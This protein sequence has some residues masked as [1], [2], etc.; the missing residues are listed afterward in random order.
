MAFRS[1]P[2]Q[3]GTVAVSI[4][5]LTAVLILILVGSGFRAANT[6]DP[7]TKAAI[8]QVH[9][10]IAVGVLILTLLRVV[11]WW[12]FDRKPEPVGGSPN[13]QE[14]IANAVHVLFYVVVLGMIASGVG[15]MALSGAAPVIFSGEGVLPDFWRYPPRVPHGLGARLLV[16]LL[17]LHVGAALYHHLVRRDGLLRR[18]WFGKRAAA[19]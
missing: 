12:K 17:I 8:L 18:M 16:A 7:A 4:H 15:L 19:G 2:D 10:P 14:R 9:L 1:T 13:W 6:V 11:W 3:Y 5:W